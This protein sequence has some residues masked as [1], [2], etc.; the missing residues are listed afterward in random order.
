MS[1]FSHSDV[2]AAFGGIIFNSD[3]ALIIEDSTIRDFSA[4]NELG[5]NFQPSGVSTL[6]IINSSI[7]GNGDASSGGGLRVATTGSGF[8]RARLKNVVI[9]KNY[10]GIAAVGSGANVDRD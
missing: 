7:A 1:L 10:V 4:A 2:T 5:I 3:A 6:T 8:V 9:D